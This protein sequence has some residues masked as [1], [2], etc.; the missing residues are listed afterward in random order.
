M[1]I[2]WLGHSCF[3]VTSDSG[4][5]IVTDPYE[6]GGFDGAIKY[7]S[8]REPA[9]VVTV[10][11]EHA[12]HGHTRMVPGS[13]IVVKGPGEFVVAGIAFYGVPA[14]HDES[15]G[16]QRGKNT[17]FHFTVDGIKIC[18][19]GDLGHVLNRDQ[20]AEIGAVDV[21]LAPVGG[22]YTIGPDQAW[23]VADQLDA[24][25]VIPM[26]F[27]TESVDFPIAS[28]DDFVRGKPSVKWLDSS[29]LVLTKDSLP[30]DRTI[31]VLKHAL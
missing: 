5:R 21:L 2:Q 24:K 10:S 22:Y 1:R 28:V 7:G 25:I 16:S 13:P 27:K 12:D 30:A 29:E 9:D 8:L 14:L 23:K 20:C 3:L 15:G 11:H 6:P 4:I 31:V 26:H 18:H 19:L 17:I